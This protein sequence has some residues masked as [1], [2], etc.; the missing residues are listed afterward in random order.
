MLAITIIVSGLY[1]DSVE[2][3]VIIPLFY[4]CLII[5]RIVI[6]NLIS[7]KSA[8]LTQNMPVIFVVNSIVTRRVLSETKAIM[9][10]PVCHWMESIFFVGEGELIN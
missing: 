1:F 9:S 2:G 5:K 10:P 4:I 7:N 8:K 3:Y 6:I